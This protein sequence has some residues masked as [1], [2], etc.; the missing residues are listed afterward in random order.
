MPSANQPDAPYA[1]GYTGDFGKKQQDVSVVS[2]SILWAAGGMIS[3]ASDVAA[4]YRALFRGRLLPLALVRE[5]Q[6]RVVDIPGSRGRQAIGLG[7]FRVQLPC[8]T[9][10]GH[11]G[12]LPG[13]TTQSFSSVDGK[14]QA[15][16]IINAG[17]ESAF[18]P[19]EQRAIGQ[20]TLLA[21]CR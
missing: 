15:V 17:E 1:H 9:T 7:L 8:G 4:F 13:Y 19:A 18:T 20:V 2:P 21:Y 16:I 11:G 5:M 14:R 3:T 10:W 6:S 12:D